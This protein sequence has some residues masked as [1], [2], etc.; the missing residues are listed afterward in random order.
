M[1]GTVVLVKGRARVFSTVW[2]YNVKLSASKFDT[3]E[4]SGERGGDIPGVVDR[5]LLDE[6]YDYR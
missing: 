1:P 4:E 2:R 5:S 3:V 6:P